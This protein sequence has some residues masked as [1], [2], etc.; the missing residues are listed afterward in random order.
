[1]ARG[2]ELFNK[3]LCPFLNSNFGHR[4]H[5][6]EGTGASS[7]K[8]I[9]FDFTSCEILRKRYFLVITPGLFNHG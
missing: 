6:G 3:N 2:Y 4:C 9:S 8:C 7:E 5:T 1:M